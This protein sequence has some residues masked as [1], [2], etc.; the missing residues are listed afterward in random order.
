[1]VIYII[2]EDSKRSERSVFFAEK[3]LVL[4]MKQVLV[5]KWTISAI[6]SKIWYNLSFFI[7]VELTI[8]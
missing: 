2:I 3:N 1:M 5:P 8:T 6:N 7:L 4:S